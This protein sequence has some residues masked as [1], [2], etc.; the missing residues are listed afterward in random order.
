MP[1]PDPETSKKV[2]EAARKWQKRRLPQ[3]KNLSAFAKSEGVPLKSL[4]TALK[5][6]RERLRKA[7][8][9]LKL[10]KYVATE[11]P[12]T[13]EDLMSHKKS[14]STSK[15]LQDLNLKSITPR[16]ASRVRKPV[17]LQRKLLKRAEKIKRQEEGRELL[18]ELSQKREED[19]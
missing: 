13:V 4:N 17:V 7:E 1:A 5:K 11:A 9:R 3:R 8:D 10:Q 6:P 18:A 19:W 2:A 16:T 14:K 15:V 12:V